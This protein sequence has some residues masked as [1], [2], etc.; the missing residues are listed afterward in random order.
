MQLK[1]IENG[2]LHNKKDLSETRRHPHNTSYTNLRDVNTVLAALRLTA[3]AIAAALLR[4]VLSR[5]QY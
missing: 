5:L 3:R 4:F 1:H 2:N